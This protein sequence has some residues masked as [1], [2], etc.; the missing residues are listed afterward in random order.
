MVC[1]Q[2]AIMWELIESAPQHLED[3][4][5][6]RNDVDQHLSQ[7]R[8]YSL[9]SCVEHACGTRGQFISLHEIGIAN[10]GITSLPPPPPPENLLHGVPPII[11]GMYPK[12]VVGAL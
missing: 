11:P 2:N 9:V 10:V 7:V 12:N 3:A 6:W 5:S 1:V 4:N 8:L